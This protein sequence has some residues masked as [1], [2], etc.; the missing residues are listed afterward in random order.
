MFGEPG[1]IGACLWAR[2]RPGEGQGRVSGKA[3]GRPGEGLGG[4]G[5]ARGRIGG[6]EELGRR[7]PLDLPFTKDRLR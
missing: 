1:L 3:G 7:G 2:G 4:Q 5:R 6:K